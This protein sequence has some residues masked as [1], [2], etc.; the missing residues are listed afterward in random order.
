MIPLPS[1]D[2]C[3]DEFWNAFAEQRLIADVAAAAAAAGDLCF[4]VGKSACSLLLD[5]TAQHSVTCFCQ[6][7]C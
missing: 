7:D 1:T 6:N 3:L 2:C 5:T 4:L